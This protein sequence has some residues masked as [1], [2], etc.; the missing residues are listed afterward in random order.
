MV[1]SFHV[2]MVFNVRL[3]DAYAAAL[4]ALTR[5]SFL[6]TNSSATGHGLI[7]HSGG[8]FWRTHFVRSARGTSAAARAAGESD[9]SENGEAQCGKSGFLGRIHSVSF[10]LLVSSKSGCCPSATGHGLIGHR[11]A[12][13]GTTHLVRSAGGMSAA[14]RTAGEGDRC[15]NDEAKCGEGGFQ[16]RFHKVSFAGCCGCRLL[17]RGFL[18]FVAA[19]AAFI[20]AALVAAVAALLA[21][22]A[23]VFGGLHFRMVLVLR[24]GGCGGEGQCEQG[25]LQCFHGLV[26]WR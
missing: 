1:I 26:F 14:S 8:A 12:V 15:E 13:F 4:M 11:G 17:F 7:G 3:F 23:T 16:C 19:R 18:L 25:E 24:E 2:W 22:G 6:F 20:V 5:T 10:H 9:D 21:A